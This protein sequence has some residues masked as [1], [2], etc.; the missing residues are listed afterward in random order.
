MV[1]GAITLV[2]F[3]DALA[4]LVFVGLFGVAFL[5]NGALEYR[6]VMAVPKPVLC[7]LPVARLVKR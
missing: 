3:V 5:V 1:F 4:A 6:R 2:P 7:E